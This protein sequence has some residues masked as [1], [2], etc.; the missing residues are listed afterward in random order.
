LQAEAVASSDGGEEKGEGLGLFKL[1]NDLSYLEEGAGAPAFDHAPLIVEGVTGAFNPLCVRLKEFPQVRPL[2][3]PL[4]L[5][6]AFK[7]LPAL[8]V[9]GR[10]HSLPSLC[11]TLRKYPVGAIA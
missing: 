1:P 5:S 4:T 9:R 7:P 6:S 3:S 8:G 2:F 11:V 10:M